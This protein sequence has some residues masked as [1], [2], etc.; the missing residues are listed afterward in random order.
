MPEGLR[1]PEGEAVQGAVVDVDAGAGDFARLQAAAADDAS[2]A[3]TIAAP[4][5]R[6]ERAPEERTPARRGRPPKAQRE[7]APKKTTSKAAPVK[8]DYTEEIT[9]AVS[10]TWMVAASIGPAQPY[11]LVLHNSADALVS[12]LNEGAKQN[13]TIRRFVTTSGEA[14]WQIQ[15]AAVAMQMGMQA[16]QMMGDKELR[17][18]AAEATK[19]QLAELVKVATPEETPDAAGTTD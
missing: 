3:A 4:P 8:D 16:Y 19:K 11:A 17:E 12:A 18:K 15:L 13:E 10:T 7:K 1:T 6:A 14:S 5:D 2:G 9:K